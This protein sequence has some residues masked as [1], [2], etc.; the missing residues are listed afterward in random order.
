MTM[1]RFSLSTKSLSA[2]TTDGASATVGKNWGLV[3]NEAIAT[4]KT[5]LMAYHCI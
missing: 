4:G 2:I 1:G 3:N 5:I